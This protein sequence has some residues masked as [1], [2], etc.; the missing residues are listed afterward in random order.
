METLMNC[1][2]GAEQILRPPNP[3]GEQSTIKMQLS[4]QIAHQDATCF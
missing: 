3:K 2:T 1:S 4:E